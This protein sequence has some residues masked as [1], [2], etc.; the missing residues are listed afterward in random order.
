VGELTSWA[1]MEAIAERRGLP[2]IP[3]LL[4]PSAPTRAFSPPV[5]RAATPKLPGWGNLLHHHLIDQL[6]WQTMRSL[7]NDGRRDTFGLPPWPLLGPYARLRREERPI[8]MAYSCH[9]VPRPVEWHS[10]IEVTGY[11]FLDRPSAWLPPA[12]LVRFLDAGPPPV[13]IG[14][15]SM[16]LADPEATVA[17]VLAAVA[18]AGCRAVIAAGWGGLTPKALSPNVFALVEA[19]MTGSF[20]AW[21]RSS[22]MAVPARRPLP[23]ERVCLR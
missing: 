22:I 15:G 14:F 5:R 7:V 3:V 13:Y 23:C 10:G 12:D 11:W 1:Q 8:L 18:Q 21:R 20:R 19:P 2:F 16:I 6:L 17:L 9:I 4:Q